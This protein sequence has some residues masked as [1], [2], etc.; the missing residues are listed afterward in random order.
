MARPGFLIF[1]HIATVK[2]ADDHKKFVRVV[3]DASSNSYKFRCNRVNPRYEAFVKK[4]GILTT[5]DLDF[6]PTPVLTM[7]NDELRITIREAQMEVGDPTVVEFAV[8]ATPEERDA[9]PV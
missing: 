4:G 1:R 7:W 3:Y 2:S 6:I 5:D 9:T 8:T